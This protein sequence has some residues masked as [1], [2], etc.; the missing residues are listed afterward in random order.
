MLSL[1]HASTLAV[2]GALCVYGAG[3]LEQPQISSTKMLSKTARLECVVSGVTIS[4]TS[5][6]W[7][8]ERPGEVI[9]FL[10]CILYDGT[11]KKE[12]SIPSGKFEVD[13]IPK[14]STSTLTI[15]NVEKQD[16]ATYYC[17]LWEFGRK[18]K[19]F[20]PGT[21]LIITDKHLDADVSPKPTIFLPSIA[22]T[23]LHKA[24]TYL[25]LL[26]NFF[27]DVI[28]IHWQEK[29]SNTILGSQEG[30]TVKTNDTYMKFSWLTVPEKSL[31]KEH[32][33]IVRHE[34]NKNGV[35]QEI[36]FPPIKTDVTTMD[37]K[38]NCSKDA[39]D[40]LLLQL[41]NTSAYYMYLLLLVKSE[42][43]FAIIAVC[44]LRRTAVCCNGERS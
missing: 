1:L 7:Y 6:Y 21:K 26:E 2:L 11:V 10:V 15:H 23:N 31:D 39:N 37:P 29:K 8:R 13:R 9:Q 12:S 28:K 24:G 35:D 33:C 42:V 27:P 16:I 22:E 30:N 43:Y 41:T 5:I 34:N 38:D 18:V 36:I 4:Q 14:T 32:R 40:A 17:A 20:G 25:C 44:L 3:H 19:L